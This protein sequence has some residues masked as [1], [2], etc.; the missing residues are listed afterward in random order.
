[1]YRLHFTPWEHEE[2][3][4]ALVDLVAGPQALPAGRL[5]DIGCG[6]G[7]DA[8]YRARH[9]WDVT[10]VDVSP[11]ALKAARRRAG[12]NVRLLQAD[13][14][15]ADLGSGYTLILDGGCLHSLAP[16]QLRAAA[17]RVTRAAEPGAVLLML[18]FSPGRRGPLL[19]RGL[20]ADDLPGVFPAWDLTSARAA[21]DVQLS[22]PARNAD[23]HWF[24]LVRR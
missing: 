21:T 10:G 17:D 23:P 1:M 8:A 13:I 19:P 3:P 9:G 2:P 11:V 5:L 15:T 7:G 18:A 16:D 14:T 12:P 20:G 4:L 24:Q 22:G 6:T